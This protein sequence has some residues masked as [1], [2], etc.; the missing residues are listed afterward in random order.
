MK[1]LKAAYFGTPYFSANFLEKLILD[2]S[3]P[4]EIM[5]VVTQPDKPVGKKH[6][7]TSSPVKVTAQKYKIPVWDKPLIQMSSDQLILSQCDVALVFAYGFKELIPLDFLKAPKLQFDI[8]EGKK[9]GFINIHPSLLPRY[10][11]S[12][13]ITFPLM[14]GDTE[15]GV[16]LFVMDEKMDHGPVIAQEKIKIALNDVRMDLEKKL[17]ELGFEMTKKLLTQLSN[18]QQ[19]TTGNQNHAFATHAHYLQKKDGF[20]PLESL[21]KALQDKSLRQ[22]ELPEVIQIYISKYSYK[23]LDP[24]SPIYCMLNQQKDPESSKTESGHSNNLIY[25][26]WRAM[27]PWPGLWTHISPRGSANDAGEELKRLKI[28]QMMYSNG[29]ATITKVQ[30]EGK[31]EV[32]FATFQKAYGLL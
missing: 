10:R 12:S 18:N 27:H 11:G 19:I 25:N 1:K 5:L 15:T 20:V 26:F 32:D 28:I 6:T 30:L 14:L 24:K 31:K 2:I 29:K 3:S 22:D 16:T 21:K 13:P 7:I 4:V 9:S 8:G 23:I 17:T